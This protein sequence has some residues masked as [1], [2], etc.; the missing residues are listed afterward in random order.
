M[1]VINWAEVEGCEGVSCRLSSNPAP[2]SSITTTKSPDPDRDPCQV[3]DPR[4]PK[5]EEIAQAGI[6]GED[7][8]GE[9]P[10]KQKQSLLQTAYPKKEEREK[11]LIFF[12]CPK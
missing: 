5:G 2:E 11:Y 1:L 4:N 6:A 3:R 12:V 10:D 9:D 7:E 8:K